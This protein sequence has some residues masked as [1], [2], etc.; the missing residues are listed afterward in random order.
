MRR[1]LFPWTGFVLHEPHAKPVH[2][3]RFIPRSYYYM[4]T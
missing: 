1:F 2:T 3:H 4:K